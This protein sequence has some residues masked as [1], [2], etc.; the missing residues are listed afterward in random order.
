MAKNDKNFKRIKNS[1]VN[2]VKQKDGQAQNINIRIDLAEDSPKKRK[3]KKQPSDNKKKAIAH[4]REMLKKY[5]EMLE[6]A[7]KNNVQIP[8]ALGA[9]ISDVPKSIAGIRELTEQLHQRADGIEHLINQAGQAPQAGQPLGGVPAGIPPPA[10]RPQPMGVMPPDPYPHPYPYPIPG[11]MTP[12]TT[13][14]SITPDYGTPRSETE[15]IPLHAVPQLPDP[16]GEVAQSLGRIEGKRMLLER[17]YNKL[18]DEIHSR[19]PVDPN[20]LTGFRGRLDAT[21]R[22]LMFWMQKNRALQNWLGTEADAVQARGAW[23]MAG[24]IGAEFDRMEGIFG[25]VHQEELDRIERDIE[26]RG[27]GAPPH[28]TTLPPQPQPPPLK[29]ELTP[30]H[31]LLSERAEFETL[32]AER[33]EAQVKAEQEKIASGVKDR[34]G[35]LIAARAREKVAEEAAQLEQQRLREAEADEPTQP[36]GDPR[37]PRIPLTPRELGLGIGGQP[38]E[39]LPRRP[40]SGIEAEIW[41]RLHRVGT[42]GEETPDA[43]IYYN[44]PHSGELRGYIRKKNPDGTY[45]LDLEGGREVVKV[46]EAHVRVR[47]IVGV[48][49]YDPTILEERP[50][51][52]DVRASPEKEA[53]LQTPLGQRGIP[54][55]QEMPPDLASLYH[56]YSEYL[57]S[58]KNNTIRLGEGQAELNPGSIERLNVQR[59]SIAK[60]LAEIIGTPGSRKYKSDLHQQLVSD[61]SINMLLTAM[62]QDTTLIQPDGSTLTPAQLTQSLMREQALGSDLQYLQPG[63]QTRGAQHLQEAE[64][65]GQL[66][67]K[68]NKLADDFTNK[69]LVAMDKQLKGLEVGKSSPVDLQ[70]ARLHVDEQYNKALEEFKTIGKEGGDRQALQTRLA[71]VMNRLKVM[72]GLINARALK[73]LQAEGHEQHPLRTFEE[74]LQH[75]FNYEFTQG[76]GLTTE[77]Q[78][79]IRDANAKWTKGDAPFKTLEEIEALSAK[80]QRKQEIYKILAAYGIVHPTGGLAGE[81]LDVKAPPEDPVMKGGVRESELEAMGVEVGHPLQGHPSQFGGGATPEERQAALAWKENLTTSANN[82]DSDLYKFAHGTKRLTNVLAGQIK[83]WEADARDKAKFTGYPFHAWGESVPKREEQEGKK[84][85]L[86]IPASRTAAETIRLHEYERRLREHVSELFR[87]WNL[88][89]EKEGMPVGAKM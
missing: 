35:A 61:P 17:E 20:E 76:A 65:E 52:V 84:T 33:A 62:Q 44:D 75:L 63:E 45:D 85:L 38:Q 34:A 9:T 60:R 6:L 2:Y 86:T 10:P 89:V 19:R 8:A 53:W 7:K 4:L 59:Q 37:V 24:N 64:A 50:G 18:Q 39:E 36:A 87:L 73:E 25:A 49:E 28:A 21:R 68:F 80:W 41:H 11:T 5:E 55:I 51:W 32:Q 74:R 71:D 15:P 29:E 43:P 72:R 54:D 70:F 77:Q 78:R 58:F 23:D 88:A 81:G 26:A 22:E 79:I 57:Q 3:R 16:R 12:S 56:D 66:S 42:G 82:P 31:V 47:E 46:D 48:P 83:K 13:P 14:Y 30:P 40:V 27:G 67:K 69:Y 1:Q